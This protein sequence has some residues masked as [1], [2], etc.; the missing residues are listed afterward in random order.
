M[1]RKWCVR[2]NA[3]VGWCRMVSDS[4]IALNRSLRTDLRFDQGKPFAQVTSDIKR[5]QVQI[6][7]SRPLKHEVR[8]AML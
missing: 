4:F 2:C 1:V 5:S 7:S 8:D 3:S 6:L